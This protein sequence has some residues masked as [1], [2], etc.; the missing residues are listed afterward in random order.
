VRRLILLVFLLVSLFAAPQRGAANDIFYVLIFGSE[1]DPKHLRLAHTFAT[2]VRAT[3]EGTDPVT[4]ALTAHTISWLPRQLD[5]R[6]RRPCPEPG[7]NLDLDSTIRVVMRDGETVTMWGPYRISP[8]IYNRSIQEVNKLN[9]GEEKYRAIDGPL[10]NKISNCIHAVGDVD[11]LFGRR[12]YALDQVGKPASAYIA[13]EI[14]KRSHYD[15]KEYDNDWLIPRL[16]LGAYP[17]EIVDHQGASRLRH[18]QIQ[19]VASRIRALHPKNW[20]TSN[21]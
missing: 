11:P 12:G 20:E 8:E 14:V 9:S 5:V 10:N 16:G 15:Q 17:I 7:I 19:S 13:K 18:Y 4:Y 2:F 21:K 6:V 3:G 1:S